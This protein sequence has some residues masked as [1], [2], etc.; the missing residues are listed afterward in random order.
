MATCIGIFY[1]DDWE[2]FHKF[3]E[4]ELA[5]KDDKFFSDNVR[6]EGIRL[7]NGEVIYQRIGG[8]NPEVSGNGGA[9]RY[10]WN[11]RCCK[12]TLYLDAKPE[13]FSSYVCGECHDTADRL[14]A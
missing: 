11:C 4:A 3:T 1:S 6:F 7:N 2:N 14:S 8:V 5:T 13:R 9:H 10:E 12:K